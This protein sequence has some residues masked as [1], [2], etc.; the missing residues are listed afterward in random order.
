MIK[1]INLYRDNFNVFIGCIPHFTDLDKQIRKF[2]FLH[3]HIIERGVAVI[4]EKKRGL[5]EDDVWGFNDVK[6]LKKKYGNNINYT[7]VSGFLGYLHWNDITKKQRI[8]YK[9]IK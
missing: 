7:K 4:F 9:K 2:V 6:K 5:Y 1:A 8:L 3:I